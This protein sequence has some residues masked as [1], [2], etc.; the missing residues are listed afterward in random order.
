M[1]QTTW[2]GFSRAHASPRRPAM[3]MRRRVDGYGNETD[4]AVRDATF[5]DDRF[6]KL[7]HRRSL[8][9]ERPDFETA[10]VV[11]MAREVANGR[12]PQDVTI[13]KLISYIACVTGQRRRPDVPRRGPRRPP[14]PLGQMRWASSTH[15]MRY[16]IELKVRTERAA[17]RLC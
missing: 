10:V 2:A 14:F 12:I 15:G 6:R 11:E 5:G 8:A 9:P 4:L 7:A 3:S 17:T 16:S 1:P 13:L